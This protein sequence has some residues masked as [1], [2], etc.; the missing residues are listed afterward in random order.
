MTDAPESGDLEVE[1][2]L[3]EVRDLE[4]FHDALVRR[5]AAVTWIVWGLVLTGW[6]LHFQLAAGPGPETAFPQY[7]PFTWIPWALAGL[8]MTRELWRSAGLEIPGLAPEPS[9]HRVL[10][11]LA[12]LGL[13][14]LGWVASPLVMDATGLLF[15]G[16]STYFLG[17]GLAVGLAAASRIVLRERTERLVGGTVGAGLVLLGF[18]TVAVLEIRFLAPEAWFLLV[19]PVTMLLLF[20]GAGAYLLRRG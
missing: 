9:T 11:L 7:H 18:L 2:A 6:S 5:T 10:L 8:W 1:D 16:A 17:A 15:V 13:A 3:R 14:M 20:S 4:G 12:I 19:A